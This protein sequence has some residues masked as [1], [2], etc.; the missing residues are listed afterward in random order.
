MDQLLL[1]T[2]HSQ[3]VSVVGPKNGPQTVYQP[4]AVSQAR[5]LP[6][7]GL[8]PGSVGLSNLLIHF[9]NGRG[10][11]ILTLVEVEAILD[12]LQLTELLVYGNGK[13]AAGWSIA[14]IEGWFLLGEDCRRA[15]YI[16]R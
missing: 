1:R 5:D 15:L 13:Q 3:F 8:L 4:S 9:L 10:D 11:L 6:V 16:S 12:Q 2:E 7:P 14:G